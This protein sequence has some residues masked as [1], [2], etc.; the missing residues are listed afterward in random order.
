MAR[1]RKQSLLNGALVLSFA[2]IAVKI[3]SVLFKLY[4]TQ[5]IGYDGKGYYA[6][7]Y[8]IYAPIYS[9][10]LAGLPTA[11]SKM[12]ASM[13]AQGRFRDVR[14]LFRVSLMLFVLVGVIGTALIVIFAYPYAKT[15]EAIDALPSIIAVAPS[16]FFCCVMS[17]YRGYYQ[18]LRDM[19]PSA[20]SQVFEAGGK[21]IFGWIFMNA[22][23]GSGALFADKIPILRDLVSDKQLSYAAAGAIAGVTVGSLIGLVYLMIRHRAASDGITPEML[24]SSPDAESAKNLTKQLLAI[25]IPVAVSSLVFNLTT[26]ID[27]WTVQ[28]RLAAVIGNHYDVVANMYPDIVRTRGFYPGAEHLTERFKNYL[29]GAYDTVLEIKNIVPTFT[30]TV[31]LSAIPVLSEAWTNRDMLTARR[32]AE[33]VVRITMLMALPAGAG[34]VA[35]ASGILNLLYG[36]NEVNAPALP[37]V[38]PIL[39]AYGVSVVFLALAQPLTSVLQA[40][41]RMDVPIKAMAIGAVVKIVANF[42]FV[43]IPSVNIQG[44]VIGSILCNIVMVV[45][46]MVVIAKETELKY[47]WSADLIRPGICAL[48]SGAAAWLTN[49]LLKKLLPAAP[50]PSH[51]TLLSGGNIA[52]VAAVVAA[53]L[54]Y[55]IALFALRAVT[56]E[57]VYMLPKGRK[58]AKVLE[59]YKLLG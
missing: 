47:N 35:L 32:S 28:N 42:V 6:N 16:V 38:A 31:G 19:V 37:Y 54:V 7:A 23:L 51:P 2:V 40:I 18:G 9:I 3:V 57:D 39:M 43:S 29:F 4:V 30:V 5:K 24:L 12:V 50:F 11:V 44:A 26:L 45:Y 21:L 53:V 33:S 13:S 59:K 58:I 17:G 8:N 49:A 46:S 1:G 48:L 27:N 20:V 56:K 55:G 36:G 15:T 34:L 52:V 41:D 10:A 22:V 14:R 25:A